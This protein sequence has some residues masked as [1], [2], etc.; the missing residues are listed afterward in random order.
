VYADYCRDPASVPDDWREYFRA[1]EMDGRAPAIPSPAAPAAPQ[2]DLALRIADAFR[3]RGHLGA[4]ISPLAGASPNPPELSPTGFGLTDSDL[5]APL[6]NSGS[7]ASP[8]TTLRSLFGRLR[9]IYCGPIGVEFMHINDTDVREWVRNRMEHPE[10]LES[11]DSLDPGGRLRI[12]AR[13]NDAVAFE[14]LAQRK[15]VGAKTFSLEGSESLLPMLDR[16]I[17]R[18]G[19]NEI[20]EIVIGMAHRGRLN[21]LANIFDKRPAEIF[22]EPP[23][24]DPATGIGDGDVKYH[25]G[26]STNR[27]GADG[28]RLHLSLCF[29]PSHLEFVIPVALGRL[30]AKQDRA[31]DMHCARGLVLLLHGDAAFAG[32]GIVQE[33]LN[34]SALPGYT[35]G[36]AIHIVINNQ[37]GFTT[38]PD[39][40]RSSRYATGVANMLEV[41]IFHV[42]A[43]NL[44]AVVR[45]ADIA[46]DYRQL[47]HRD[48]VIDLVGY[49]R[50]GHNEMDEPA[51][52]QPQMQRAIQ[53]RPSVREICRDQLVER[54]DITSEQAEAE[55]QAC[56]ERTRA[57]FDSVPEESVALTPT[58]PSGTWAGYHGGIE[59]VEDEVA[60][61]IGK[62]WLAE[63]LRKSVLLPDNFRRHPRLERL[64]QRR[65][66]MA[67]GTHSL[68]WSAAEALAFASLATTGVRIRL[69]GQDTARGT[70]SHRHAVLH[71]FETGQT[72]APLQHIAP[73]QAPV[74]IINSPLSEAAVLAFEYGYSLESPD[75]LVLWEAQ[76]GDFV[77]AAQ[78]IIDQ[79][80]T[81]AEDKWHRLSGLVLLLPHGFEGQGP[82][83]SSARIERFLQAAAEN[84][85]QVVMPS[86]PAQ[87]FHV[88]RRHALRRW[89]K[90][91]I[92]FTPK[93]LLRHP[94]AVS[95]LD[96]FEQGRFEG[97]IADFRAA[98]ATKRRILL[99]SG[100]IFF[101]LAEARD[102]G[103]RDDVAII[104]IEQFYPWRSEDLERALAGYSD[105]IPAVWV[106]EEPRNMGAWRYLRGRCG[107]LL[108]GKFP[109]SAMCPRE[110]ASPAIGSSVIHR[111]RQSELI[112]SAFGHIP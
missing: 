104:R 93:S 50:R 24:A 43:D 91:L 79:F 66:E 16:L 71:D 38:T 94:Q 68:D 108:A 15:H 23:E 100:K 82:E 80:L 74:E 48:V 21:V 77:N 84:N 72:Y 51:Y 30:R 28:R 6:T 111:R 95:T 18:A 36:G 96:E 7:Q 69:S 22:Q 70:F 46:L 59:N 2:G 76:Y 99:C 9:S 14:E 101:E 33:S 61:G 87:Y 98:R 12:L 52:T 106:Q 92:V 112:A 11:L 45:V 103:Q 81:S 53:E 63:T 62:D 86:T 55:F 37:I 57:G 83:H 110:S 64:A 26:H 13:L 73:D 4:Q 29:N 60:T 88:L 67:E 97:V 25:L 78:V 54:G 27:F 89:R 39:E 10:Q 19:R 75:A 44:G 102:A 8:A 34:L 20:E 56:R 90:P 85:I 58:K 5:D 109:F 32:Q 42:N 31:A 65:I 1:L 35:V 40:G 49:R 105:G 47:F 3:T 17:D 107:L 41:P